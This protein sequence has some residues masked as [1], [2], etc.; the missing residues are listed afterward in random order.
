V[1][2]EG[3]TMAKD[4]MKDQDYKLNTLMILTINAIIKAED[5]EIQK[6]R[7][8]MEEAGALFITKAIGQSATP[9]EI[10]RWLLREH[11]SVSDLLRRMNKKGLVNLTKDLE[12]KNMI[13]V[14]L[15]EKGKEALKIWNNAKTRHEIASVLTQD[16]STRM[17]SYLNKLRAKALEKLS[18]DF[19]PPFP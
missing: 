5:K 4:L 10:S 6:Y 19:V 7:I 3:K 12:R 14:S 15:T 1:P 8:S 9:A 13:R 16:E 18:I 2:P 11:H 17:I